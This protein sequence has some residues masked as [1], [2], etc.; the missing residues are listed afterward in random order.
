MTKE[1]SQALTLQ[2]HFLLPCLTDNYYSS[3]NTLTQTETNTYEI[4]H[5]KGA[6]LL[7]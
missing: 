4:L 6:F 2:K 3:T 7:C 5:N 1:D